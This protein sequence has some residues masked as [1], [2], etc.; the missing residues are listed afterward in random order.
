MVGLQF[1]GLCISRHVCASMRSRVA[2]SKP[3]AHPVAPKLCRRTSPWTGAQMCVQFWCPPP[4]NYLAASMHYCMAAN[5]GS[6]HLK[7]ELPSMEPRLFSR[8]NGQGLQSV[9][10]KLSLQWSHDYLVV[11]TAQMPRFLARLEPS[12]E[13]RLFSRGNSD[14]G[15]DAYLYK[16]SF[17]GATTI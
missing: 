15:K 14:R 2:I 12:M 13:P 1:L 7:P 10:E 9:A 8:E 11:E 5:N 3:D 6:Y 4:C 16:R 17:N